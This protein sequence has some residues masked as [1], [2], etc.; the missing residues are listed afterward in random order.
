MISHRD[1]MTVFELVLPYNFNCEQGLNIFVDF[2][3][4]QRAERFLWWHA[5]NDKLRP[6][7]N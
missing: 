6:T 3:H 2:P 7:I 4:R 1:M 5:K